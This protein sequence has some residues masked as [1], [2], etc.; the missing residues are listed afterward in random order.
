MGQKF[1]G[2]KDI[3]DDIGINAIV[4]SMN[5]TSNDICKLIVVGTNRQVSYAFQ[6][7]QK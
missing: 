7:W 4:L 1:I 5:M 3:P 2:P 6:T